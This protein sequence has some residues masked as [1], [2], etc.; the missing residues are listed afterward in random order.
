MD[1]ILKL[2]MGDLNMNK[3]AKALSRIGGGLVFLALIE[4]V[5][6]ITQLSQGFLIVLPIFVVAILLF[7]FGVMLY[8]VAGELEKDKEKLDLLYEKVIGKEE[9]SS[10]KEQEV[11]L[12]QKEEF[13]EKEKIVM[14]RDPEY[15]EAMKN[16]YADNEE[17]F[18]KVKNKII[19]SF[20]VS[21][22]PPSL[23]LYCVRY[24][25][26]SFFICFLETI[27]F[28][29]HLASWNIAIIIQYALNAF[30]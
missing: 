29:L 7:V 8:G 24:F 3:L 14:E 21:G 19:N 16:Y 26:N 6:G 1:A 30:N 11:E 20:A 4:I 18:E 22:N 17:E 15:Y 25:F 12:K 5:I 27:N 23:T 13:A 10:I 28:L 2:K 9:D